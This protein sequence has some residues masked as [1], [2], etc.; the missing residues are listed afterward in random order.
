MAE[1]VTRAL[2]QG[3]NADDARLR[4]LLDGVTAQVAVGRAG[5]ALGEDFAS[6]MTEL[7]SQSPDPAAAFE[8]STMIGDYL[9]AV[10]SD[11]RISSDTWSALRFHVR[12]VPEA[13][14]FSSSTV[15]H[16][17]AL[18]AEAEYW[19]VQ[20]GSYG[21]NERSVFIL[22]FEMMLWPHFFE[23]NSLPKVEPFT[24]E[25]W[26]GYPGVLRHGH[27]ANGHLVTKMSS[28]V[29]GWVFIGSC[30]NYSGSPRLG[31]EQTKPRT[32]TTSSAVVTFW[33][34]RRRLRLPSPSTSAATT[35]PGRWP[36]AA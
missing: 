5:E 2:A 32:C 34:I 23:F 14:F 22:G 1:R 17:L 27:V 26:T 25:V 9:A 15:Q 7:A 24:D 12:F 4:E 11:R 19:S 3:K 36:R 29:G 16:V 18:A 21:G 20:T 28:D 8:T 13:D 30:T 10:E 33:P 31:E 6:L 35:R